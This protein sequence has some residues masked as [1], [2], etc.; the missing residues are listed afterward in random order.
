M[1]KQI[2]DDMKMRRSLTRITY[3][4][5]ENNKGTQNL[6]FIG[7]KTRGIYLAQRLAER[8]NQ[9]EGVQVPTGSLDVT[10][11]RD[12]VH[13][14]DVGDQATVHGAD[15]PVDL[16]GK[17]VI[18]IDDVIFTGRTVRAALNALME[19]GR[20]AK[21]SL[22]VLVDRGHRELPIRPDFVGKNIPTGMDEQVSVAMTE[23]DGHDSVTIEKVVQPH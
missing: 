14:A 11:Y 1:T 18:L 13:M 10:L 4:I 17:H 21:V 22:A 20:P 15:I 12:D 7:I 16:T 6:V 3:E 5:V 23:V 9:L 19:Y 2:M 8:L